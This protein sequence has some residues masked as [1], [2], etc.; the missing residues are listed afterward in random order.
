M[1]KLLL[2][3]L[4]VLPLCGYA[5]KGMQGIGGG[6]MTVFGDFKTY[7][8]RLNASGGTGFCLKYDYHLTDRVGFSANITLLDMEFE[9]LE[10]Y[11]REI[12]NTPDR[13]EYTETV[14][15]VV[16]NYRSSSMFYTTGGLDAR[17]FMNEVKPFRTYLFSGIDLG[18]EPVGEEFVIGMRAGLGFNWR[19]A[20]NCLLQIELPFS[21]KWSCWYHD[22]VW[23]YDHSGKELVYCT[24]WSNFVDNYVWGQH[25]DYSNPDYPNREYYYDNYYHYV[26]C[27]QSG[28]ESM[29]FFGFTP[30]VSILFT[31]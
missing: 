29:E 6:I 21:A 7:R 19:L 24:D 10:S 15:E 22:R 27:S 1:K 13:P 31:F 30:S 9:E 2:G 14:Y 17:F 18:V 28:Y 5:Q 25:Y 16:E 26:S 12:E 23:L 4:L 3:L 11:L 20:Y 8:N